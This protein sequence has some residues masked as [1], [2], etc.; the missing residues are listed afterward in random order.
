MI[1]FNYHHY[2]IRAALLVAGLLTGGV[3]LT[4]AVALVVG[5]VAV[6]YVSRNNTV[7]RENLLCPLLLILCII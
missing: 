6:P 5:F 7:R 4:V 2:A 1:I 3:T